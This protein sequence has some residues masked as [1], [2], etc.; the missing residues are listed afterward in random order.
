MG[1]DFKV[2]LGTRVLEWA[3]F[4]GFGGWVGRV[5]EIGVASARL[6]PDKDGVR[7]WVWTFIHGC[8]RRCELEARA[9]RMVGGGCSGAW[10]IAGLALDGWAWLS[11]LP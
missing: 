10:S 4:G 1:P 5:V 6:I 2:F 8:C 9:C 3:G 11:G 7:S